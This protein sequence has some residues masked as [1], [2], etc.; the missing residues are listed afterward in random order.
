MYLHSRKC[1]HKYKILHLIC[2]RRSNLQN[3][4]ILNLYQFTQNVELEVDFVHSF[5]RE[6]RA[7]L[8]NPNHSTDKWLTPVTRWLALVLGSQPCLSVTCTQI[9]SGKVR[10]LEQNFFFLSQTWFNCSR[11]VF[12]A[13]LL[14]G[15]Q[16]PVSV[17]LVSYQ[18]ILV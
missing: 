14:R 6:R 7:D 16:F 18:S 17:K 4:K 1:E 10:K 11:P 5:T 9:P 13:R 12:C 2:L 15:V 3:K 8:V